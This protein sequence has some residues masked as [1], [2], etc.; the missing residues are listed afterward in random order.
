MESRK[1]STATVGLHDSFK[2]PQSRRPQIRKELLQ[3]LEPLCIEGIDAAW[4]VFTHVNQAGSA[5]HLEVLRDSLL[6]DVEVAADLT[7]GARPVAHELE[8]VAS[9]RL[10]ECAEDRLRGHHRTVWPVSTETSSLDLHKPR[11]VG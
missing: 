8:H 4:T 5:E 10:D 11:L 1:T 9:T 2:A 6:G 3:C 7:G